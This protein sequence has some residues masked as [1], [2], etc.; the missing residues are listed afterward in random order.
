[1]RC[2]LVRLGGMLMGLTAPAAAEPPDELAEVV[3]V[4]LR[5][6]KANDSR[7]LRTLAR[8]DD[9]GLWLIADELRVRGEPDAAQKLARAARPCLVRR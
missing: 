5:S 4:A 8:R 3:D 6:A 7:A 1:M 9:P 2:A